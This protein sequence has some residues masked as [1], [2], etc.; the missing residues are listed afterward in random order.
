M[1]KIGMVALALIFPALSACTDSA[2]SANANPPKPPVDP[3]PIVGNWCSGGTHYSVTKDSFSSPNAQCS[4][5]HLGNF[6]GT[7]MASLSCNRQGQQ[8]NENITMTPVGKA[9][10]I[11]F[12]TGT[13]RHTTASRCGG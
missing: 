10:Q 4:I 1:R 5:T 2:P 13:V 9:L 12:L 7:F 3:T 11:S 6:E 8:S